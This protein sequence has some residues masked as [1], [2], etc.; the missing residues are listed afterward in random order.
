MCAAC[1]SDCCART[2]VRCSIVSCPRCA[3]RVLAHASISA[4]A[5]ASRSNPRSCCSRISECVA[6]RSLSAKWA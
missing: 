5:R 6:T 3:S 4:P 1:S 2:A